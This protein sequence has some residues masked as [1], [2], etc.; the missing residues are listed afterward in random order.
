MMMSSM[1]PS[2]WAR[3]IE[4]TVATSRDESWK[5]RMTRDL[6]AGAEQR[7]RR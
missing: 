7:R 5:R 6:D 3:P 1:P 2:S 4:A